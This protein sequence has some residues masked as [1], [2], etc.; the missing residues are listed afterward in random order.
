[1]GGVLVGLQAS[2]LP[3]CDWY[4]V[5]DTLGKQCGRLQIRVTANEDV[6]QYL[7]AEQK[8]T[9]SSEAP[10]D[11][12]AVEAVGSEAIASA[13]PVTSNDDGTAAD[14]PADASTAT[15]E[16][17]LPEADSDPL[18]GINTD[19][20]DET[21]R[22]K[23][24]ELEDISKRLKLRLGDVTDLA[25]FDD[26]IDDVMDAEFEQ[27][28]NTEPDEEEQSDDDFDWSVTGEKVGVE[29]CE[30]TEK[31]NAK[32]SAQKVAAEKN[33]DREQQDANDASSGAGG[34]LDMVMG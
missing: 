13:N 6:A 27:Y 7:T 1:M 10:V 31:G 3:L 17:A 12:E 22:R 5:T 21:I 19:A 20:L 4:N 32:E 14:E 2:A 34:E 25:N 8:L 28:L 24:T 11:I 15:V 33:V 23:F 9:V 18:I 26:V 29:K 30:T 16:T